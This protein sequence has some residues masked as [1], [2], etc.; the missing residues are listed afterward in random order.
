[1]ANDNL[2]EA[3]HSLIRERADW[4][5]KHREAME[6]VEQLDTAI[7]SLRNLMGISAQKKVVSRNTNV[8]FLNPAPHASRLNLEI[9][10]LL[11]KG[12]IY[13]IEGLI[14]LLT[15]EV[16]DEIPTVEIKS[17]VAS[18]LS[19]FKTM[20]WVTQPSTGKF[21]L[22]EK[23]HFAKNKLAEAAEEGKLE[24]RQVGDVKIYKLG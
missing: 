23:Y 14:S 17:K 13:T 16:R 19:Y 4:T 3:L 22:I 7:D 18:I 20:G 15:P 12:T 11:R 9:R 5:A 24:A 8:D 1:M 2:K 21:Q 10:E 6:K